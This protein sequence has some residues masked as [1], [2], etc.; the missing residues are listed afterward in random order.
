MLSHGMLLVRTKPKDIAAAGIERVPRVVGVQDGLPVLEDKRVL[1]VA[2]VIWC[3]GFEAGLSW[4][5]LSVLG[6]QE[7]MHERGVVASEPGLYFV[8][9][10]FLYAVSSSQ[11]QGIGRDAAYIA[12]QIAARASAAATLEGHGVYTTL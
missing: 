5:D 12:A 3:T 7:P 9:L 2:N 4:I 10:A 11:I 1:K 6:D 8:G